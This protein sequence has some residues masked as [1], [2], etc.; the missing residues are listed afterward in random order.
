MRD[1]GYQKT[2]ALKKIA[3]V[4]GI[5]VTTVQYHLFPKIR[6]QMKD[7][8]ALQIKRIR[9]DP[10]ARA[11]DNAYERQYR[12][13]RRH[14]PAV[15]EQLRK[16]GDR[17]VYPFVELREAIAVQTGV[18]FGIRVLLDVNRRYAARAEPL[19]YVSDDAS[20]VRFVR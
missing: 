15:L 17:E 11:G 2:A 3:E 6:Q 1:R 19:F 13:H 18:R 5:S 12:W 7:V 9:S 16:S 10:S 14:L 20:S 4:Y 8:A